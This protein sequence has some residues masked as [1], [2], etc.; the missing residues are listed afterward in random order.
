[1]IILMTRPQSSLL[2]AWALIFSHGIL[3]VKATKRTVN[4]DEEMG[5]G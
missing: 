2:T 1:M 3:A 4:M 5:M